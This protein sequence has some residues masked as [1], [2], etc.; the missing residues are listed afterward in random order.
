M[1]FYC[2]LFY[3]IPK[4]NA[5]IIIQHNVHMRTA[6]VAPLFS[7]YSHIIVINFKQNSSYLHNF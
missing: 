6:G 4:V 3:P 1:V 2:C 5:M 7:V